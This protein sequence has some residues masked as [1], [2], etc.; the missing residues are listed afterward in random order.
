[1]PFFWGVSLIFFMGCTYGYFHV[2]VPMVISMSCTHGYSYSTPSGLKVDGVIIFP[3]QFPA[4]PPM[5]YKQG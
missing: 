1:M 5:D 2:I 4:M 3:V